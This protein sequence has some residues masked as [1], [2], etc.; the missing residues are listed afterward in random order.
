[1]TE[2][3]EKAGIKTAVGFNY[4]KNPMVALAQEIVASGEIGDAGELPRHP[5]RGL[6]DRRVG[7][8]HLASRREG[9]PWRRR[10]SRQPHHLDRPLRRRSDRLARRADQDRGRRAAD[11]AGSQADAESARRRRSAG[12]GDLR[13]R[14]DRL[15]RGELGQGRPQDAAR[16]RGD[17][18]ERLDLRRPRADERV[19]ALH[20]R[21][22]ARP[23]GLQDHPRRPRAPVLQ[24]VRAG[25]R[26]PPRLQRHQDDRGPRAA[27]RACR[28]PAVPARLPRSLGDPARGRRDRRIR[29]ASGSGSTCRV[30][31]AKRAHA[32]LGVAEEDAWARC[33]LPT[34]RSGGPHE[35]DDRKTRPASEARGHR[36]RTGFVH[37]AGAS[38]RGAPG[39]QFR[40]RRLGPLLRPGAVAEGGAGDR[41]RGRPGLWRAGRDVRAGKGARRRH[42]GRGD[43]DAERQPLRLVAD[44]ARAWARHHLRQAARH[45]S[46]RRARPARDASKPRASSSARPS[47][48][49]ASRSSARRARWCAMATSA[50]SAW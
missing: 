23:A 34:Y 16:L 38:R 32:G 10:G 36:R 19:A 2:A 42:G 43:H 41:R 24:G 15:A 45:Q 28:R 22:A 12:A 18:V 26:P 33:A 49:P 9:R 40:D 44:C 7:A 8:V 35:Q 3:A 20:D 14:R 6:H 1:M 27:H 50:R 13:Q 4:L 11:R 46:R 25:A 48:T 31:K 17:R 37:R 21:P 29:P 5:C 47:T 39:R 30:G